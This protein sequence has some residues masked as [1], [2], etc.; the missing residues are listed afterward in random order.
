MPVNK[1]SPDIYNIGVLNPTL[2]VFDIVM[3]TEYGTTYNAYL[4]KDEVC[5]LV[6][7]VHERFS[8]EYISQLESQCDISKI[9]YIIFNHTEPDH[10]G[11]LQRLL[12]LNPDITVVG[13]L[14]AIKNLRSITNRDFN[15]LAVKTGDTLNLGKRTLK[16]YQAPN[17][18]WPDSMFTYSPED[19]LVFTCDFLGAHYCEEA[20]VD[21]GIKFS[22]YYDFAFKAYYDAI[23]SPFKKFVL[24]GL[25]ILE[26]LDF[27]MV[28]TSHGP[29]LTATA[30]GAMQKYREWSTPKEKQVK[31]AAIV[32]VSAYGYT[33]KLAHVAREVLEAQGYC[34][35]LFDL[36]KTEADFEAVYDADILLIGAPTINRNALKP[37]WDFI[38]SL[39]AVSIAGKRAGV[40]GSYGWS[41]EAVPTLSRRLLDL[42]LDVLGDGMRVI[43]SPSSEELASW[44]E[45]IN[46]LISE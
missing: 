46:V 35:K 19:K 30:I 15:T 1:L 29:V 13:T 40:F 44:R 14:S 16:F 6:E 39:D 5:A 3:R 4:I 21:L 24:A 10:S 25:N 42:K 9:K 26:G 11:S 27:D 36:V 7:T 32:Y 43:F 18:H 2:R 33:M 31:S 20:A 22:T 8:Q 38:S 45:Y 17:L 12:E 34:V 28:C 41:G 23:F 37:I